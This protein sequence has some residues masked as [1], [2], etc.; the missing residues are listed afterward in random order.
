MKPIRE[1]SQIELA[2]FVQTHLQ[3]Q[4]VSVILSGGRLS[5]FIVTINMFR[6]T[7]T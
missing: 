2:A 4:G 3:G 1:M 5:L 6:L 7:L